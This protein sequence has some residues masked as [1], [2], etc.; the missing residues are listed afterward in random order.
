MNW[1]RFSASHG[2]FSVNEMELEQKLVANQTC[3]NTFMHHCAAS[4]RLASLSL[5]CKLE[6]MASQVV[7]KGKK[8]WRTCELTHG[9]LSSH[10]TNNTLTLSRPR[11]RVGVCRV[12]GGPLH[13]AR[14]SAVGRSVLL[15]AAVTGFGQP[16]KHL[17]TLL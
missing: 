9:H 16:G 3:Y 11:S 5:A 6:R 13:H 7:C 17:S 12:P 2:A 8:R 4:S 10:R 1:S 15:H 14:L